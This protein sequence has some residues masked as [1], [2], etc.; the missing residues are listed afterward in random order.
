MPKAVS[1][2]P[3][4]GVFFSRGSKRAAAA[5]SFFTTTYGTYNKASA[6][7]LGVSRPSILE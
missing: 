2:V 7:M 4:F 6:A 3:G 5:H 1:A